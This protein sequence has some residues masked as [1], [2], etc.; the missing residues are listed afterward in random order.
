[1][2]IKEF[3]N[4]YREA[5]SEKAELPVAF[6][7]SDQVEGAL[8]KTQGCM[9]KALPAIRA[10]EIVSMN[11]ETIGCGGGKFYTGFAEMNDY[12]PTF[13]SQ[14]EKYK[15]TPEQVREQIDAMQV[16]RTTH[17]YL[18][19]ARIDRLPTFEGIEGLFFLATPDILTGLCTWAFF[20]TTAS[21]AVATLF[22]S[23]CS[24]VITQTVRENQANGHRTFL[25]FFDPSVRPYV[26]SD[27][28]S[29]AVPMS[30]FRVMLDTMRS[31]FLYDTHAWSKV[32]SRISEAGLISPTPR[33]PG[34]GNE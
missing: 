18:H 28:L 34:C 22:G 27:R 3:I 20:D 32:K 16:P 1:M 30:R 23:G 19:L 2:E 29:F 6:W 9:F 21:D 26:E 14:K 11:A 33:D 5:F 15:Q 10:G 31:C 4:S 25:G 17:R 7:Y 8:K 12:I 13:V 24:A